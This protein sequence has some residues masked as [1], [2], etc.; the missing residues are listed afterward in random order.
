MLDQ[1][2]FPEDD[3]NHS[4]LLD[5]HTSSDYPE[6]NTFI[7][8]IYTAHFSGPF[9]EV[10]EKHL[11]VVLLHLYVTWS[12]DPTLYTAV[13]FNKSEYK[14]GSRYNALHISSKIIDII[15]ELERLGLI[16]LHLGFKDRRP[17]GRGRLTRIRPLEKLTSHFQK[18]T[19]SAFEINTHE[20]C[21]SVILKVGEKENSK[22]VEYED[23]EETIRM[24]SFLTEYNQLLR[25]T[26]ID[27]CSMDKAYQTRWDRK[28]KRFKKVV[29]I[30]QQNKFTRR[31]FA[32]GSW[33]L[34]GRFYGGWWQNV[35]RELRQD[36]RINGERT[37]EVDYSGTHI[38]YLYAL[39]GINY[40]QEIGDDPY[41]L[42]IPEIDDPKKSRWLVKN[43]VLMTLNAKS[44]HEA[45]D[46]LQE[47]AN[48]NKSKAPQVRLDYR[49]LGEVLKR[50]KLKHPLISDAFCSDEGVRLQNLDGQITE[51]VL[52]YF[53]DMGVA[54][55][56][57]HDS[58]VVPERLSDHLRDAMMEAWA[59]VLGLTP[60]WPECSFEDLA[61]GYTRTNQIG[62]VDELLGIDDLEH[63][64]IIHL[65]E[66]KYVSPRYKR[67]LKA[68]E[69]WK[70]EK[71]G[72]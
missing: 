12:E 28:T 69:A 57:I 64:R 7:H 23:T 13:S 26:H 65:K 14:A 30:N 20:A 66:Q 36:I 18:A 46:A 33:S 1:P 58:F 8:R 27:C 59:G 9:T 50:I 48:K 6:V 47:E 45:F 38:T 19:F 34:G 41:E 40:F 61:M 70:K 32:R 44:E 25:D 72:Q 16:E 54:A 15:K 49:F 56:S 37:I 71:E 68:F 24:R 53:M 39:K 52:Q 29:R 62:Y 11:K 51:R 10:K 3:L 67:S 4:V 5:V 35:S 42:V 22:E 2:N 55:L 21:E 43:L 60:N 63:K 17:R 31:I